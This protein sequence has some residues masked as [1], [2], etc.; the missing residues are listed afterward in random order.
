VW[1]GLAAPA[2]DADKKM[3]GAITVLFVVTTPSRKNWSQALTRC[4]AQPLAQSRTKTR[5]TAK[6]VALSQALMRRPELKSGYIR[7]A[8][9]WDAV[10][11]NALTTLA[12]L[13]KVANE[14]KQNHSW[15]PCKGTALK[16]SVSAPQVEIG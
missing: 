4:R 16:A 14:F 1:F 10:A 13:E 12:T 2:A 9:R 3:A 8:E 11:A 15:E 6:A 5:D 7:W